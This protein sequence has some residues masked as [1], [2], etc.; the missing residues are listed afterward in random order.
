[1]AM[2]ID[3]LGLDD[4]EVSLGEQDDFG[5]D[6][7]EYVKN[8]LDDPIPENKETPIQEPIDKEI[9]SEEVEDEDLLTSYLKSKGINPTSVK[10][11][12][13]KG[14]TE[15][16]DFSTLS[17]EEQLEIL[18][19]QDEPET[20]LEE[21]EILL[22]NELRGNGLTAQEYIAAVKRQAIQE[23]LESGQG[24]NE[25]RYDVDSYTDEELYILDKKARIPDLSDE[26]IQQALEHAK[27]NQALFEKEVASLRTEYKQ[28]EQQ[29]LDEREKAEMAER[30]EELKAFEESI[31]N[32]IIENSE[33]DFGDTVLTFSEDDMQEI[34][35]FILDSDSAGVRYI[36]KAL[37][38]PK[39]LVQMSWFALKGQEAVSQ[40]SDYYK[41]KIKEVAQYNYNKGLKDAAKNGNQTK[42]T[43]VTK[44]NPQKSNNKSDGK[45]SIDDLGFED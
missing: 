36:Q 9:T 6:P 43:V 8:L 15:E 35:S 22:L 7:D 40:I 12:N 16:V 38:D 26:D 37:S 19:Y 25:Q 3:N 11:L 33:L 14:E 28:I 1:M 10:L 24:E 29:R 41:E 4:D 31:S 20:D 30:E 2:N 42:T 5:G 23:Y 45:M 39:T 13:D 21:D 32:A 44:P 17:R 27:S 18:R 34:A